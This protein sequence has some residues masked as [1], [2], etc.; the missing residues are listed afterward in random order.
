MQELWD[1]IEIYHGRTVRLFILHEKKTMK[2]EYLKLHPLYGIER[3]KNITLKLT[4]SETNVYKTVD[5]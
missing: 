3:K 5:T 4:I 1:L 2:N